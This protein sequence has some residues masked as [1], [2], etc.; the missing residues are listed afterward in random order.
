LGESLEGIERQWRRGALGF[1]ST[2][3]GSRF[4]TGKSMEYGVYRITAQMGRIFSGQCWSANKQWF[5]YTAN[6]VEGKGE[7][8]GDKS[9]LVGTLRT[10]RAMLL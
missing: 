9:Y 4:R 3:N 5:L 7:A 6:L 2:S 10:V 8:I 1:R